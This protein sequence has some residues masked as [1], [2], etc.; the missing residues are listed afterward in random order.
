MGN[1]K[2]FTA[3]EKINDALNYEKKIFLA[4]SIEMGKAEEWQNEVINLFHER[5]PLLKTNLAIFNPRRKEWNASWEQKYENPVLSQQINWELRGLSWAD[6]VYFYFAPN[7]ISPIS[8]LEL[9]K[10]YE[11]AIVFCNDD[12]SREANVNIFCEHY[13]IKQVTSHKDAVNLILK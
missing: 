11:K 10:F 3:P 4:G 6:I 13:K 2:I 7:T 1:I 5:Q 8:L 9:G 12:Y